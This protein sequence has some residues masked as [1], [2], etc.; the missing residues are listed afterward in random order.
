[1]LRLVKLAPKRTN[2]VTGGAD[3]VDEAVRKRHSEPRREELLP[4]LFRPLLDPFG[5]GVKRAPKA[6]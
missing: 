6:S 5:F 2:I 1:M 3:L 4:D